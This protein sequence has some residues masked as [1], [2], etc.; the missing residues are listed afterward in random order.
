MKRIPKNRSLQSLV[1]VITVV[2]MLF[3][4]VGFVTLLPQKVSAA[5]D[6]SYNMTTDEVGRIDEATINGAIWKTLPVSDPTGS[7][8]WHAFFRVDASPT[9]RGYNTDGRPLQFDE[10]KSATFTHAALLADVPLVQY[11]EGTGPL[12]YEFQLDVNESKKT[13]YISLDQFQVWTTNDPNL[14]GYTETTGYPAGSFAVG[15]AELVYDLDGDGD[16]WIKMDYRW[17][18]GSGKRDYKVLVPQSAFAGKELL[19]VVI[20]TRHGISEPCDDGF[21]EWGVAVYPPAPEIDITKT[22]D[23]LSKVGDEIT[24]TITITNTG[25]IGLEH[26]TVTDTLLGDLSAYFADT[27]AVGASESHDFPYEVQPG[28]PDPLPNTATVHSDPVG[29]LITDVTDS[30]S[31]SVDLVHPG[32]DVTKEADNTITKV[33]DTV[34]FTITVHNTGDVDLNLVSFTDTLMTDISSHFSSVLAAGA[35]ES[36]EYDY[37]TQAGDPDPLVNTAEAHYSITGL[38]NDITD[39]DKVEVDVLH[40]NTKVTI[41]PDVFETFPGGNVILTITEQNTGD[42]ALENIHVELDPGDIILTNAS[43]SF[44]A[45]SDIGSDGILSPVETWTWIYQ[46]TISVD[47]TFIAIGYGK[48]VGLP[49]IITYPGYLNEQASVEVKVVGATRTMGFWK[50]HLSFTT[51]IFD[52]Y[53]HSINLGWKNVTN[54]NDL[55]GIMWANVAKVSSGKKRSALCQARIQASQQAIAALLNSSMPG[56]SPLP[57]GITPTSIATTIGGTDINA[58]KA[59]QSVLDAYNNSGDTVAFDPSLPPTYKATPKDAE[60]IANI[61]FADCP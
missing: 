3:S 17:N 35:T 9:E 50:T 23:E 26:I 51:Y 56:G 16:T 25:N 53:T 6:P 54:I 46:T 30:A 14:L 19:Y 38:D 18:T 21:E 24:Y 58:I 36:Y 31:H 55:M 22:G 47:T 44:V 11:P 8:V 4:M 48:V 61:P 45:A 2:A 49:N 15:T 37:V 33:G 34:H 28:D 43:P 27:L 59:L 41:T 13:P 10:M 57:A 12:Y 60:S 52:T 1:A 7:G 29:A 5:S 40:P 32:V 39:K 42:V 20:F